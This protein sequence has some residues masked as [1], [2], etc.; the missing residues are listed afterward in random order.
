MKNSKESLKHIRISILL[1]ILVLITGTAGYMLI[2]GWNLIDSFYMTIISIT[3]TGFAEVN[4]LSAPGKIFTAFLIIMGLAT[5]AYTA[6]RITQ[7]FVEEYILRRRRM[8]EKIKKLKDH[9]IVCGF[10]R[11]GKQI[12]KELAESNIDFVVIENDPEKVEELKESSYLFIEGD[13]TD[14]EILREA[15][16]ERA[17][18]LVSVVDKD[19]DNVFVTLS[20]RGL[21]DRVLIVTR[22]ISENTEKKLYKAG[23]NR[24]I[25]PYELGGHRMVQMLL[26]PYVVD[27]ID[28][29]GRRASYNLVMEEIPIGENSPLVDLTLSQTPIRRELNI[30]VVAIYSPDGKFHY[31]PGP[32]A[33][34]Q[35]N[36]TLIVIG[37]EK[38]V[39]KLK[40]IASSGL[41]E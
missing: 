6:G 23:A 13:A 7:Y 31:N 40:K 4:P 26:R 20:A 3:T 24:V 10:G 1:V 37:E 33:H 12:C 11:M 32:N 29:I 14:D 2:E 19:A 36:N 39:E 25:K 30:I 38:N 17:K 8:K 35:A 28:V 16:I 15:G 41:H 22:A 18:G 5:I 27:F 9:Y 34:I 21:N